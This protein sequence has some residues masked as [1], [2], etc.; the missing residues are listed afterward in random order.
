M[1]FNNTADHCN[2]GS[3]TC[4]NRFASRRLL[5]ARLICRVYISVDLYGFSYLVTTLS[6]TSDYCSCICRIPT[7]IRTVQEQCSIFK[8]DALRTGKIIKKKKRVNKRDFYVKKGVFFFLQIFA[9]VKYCFF[10]KIYFCKKRCF[11]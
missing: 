4:Y 5:T 6:L 3:T 8:H 11:S 2:A 10:T 9:V 7:R 1:R